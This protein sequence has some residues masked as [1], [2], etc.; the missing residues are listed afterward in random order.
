LAHISTPNVTVVVVATET[1]G[2]SASKAEHTQFFILFFTLITR[3]HNYVNTT[4]LRNTHKTEFCR[5]K[6]PHEEE[7]R[8][9]Q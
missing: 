2:N 4:T 7:Q 9:P 6:E 1:V 3:L 5:K 8:L